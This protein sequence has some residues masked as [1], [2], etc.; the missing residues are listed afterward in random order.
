[1][2]TKVSAEPAD[3]IGNKGEPMHYLSGILFITTVVFMAADFLA[4]VV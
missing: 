1:V 4:A 3:T 2:R